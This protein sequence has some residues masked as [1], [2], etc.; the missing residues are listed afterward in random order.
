LSSNHRRPLYLYLPAALLL[1]GALVYGRT[2]GA[3]DLET[4]AREIFPEAVSVSPQRDVL[5]IYDGEE[6]LIGWAGTG[7]ATGYGG[8]MVLLV[9][10]DTLGQVVGIRVIEQRETPIFWR[11]VRSSTYFDRLLGSHFD[12][13]DYGYADVVGVTGATR[14][15]DA[16]VQSVRMAVAE[17]AG[18]VFDVRLPLP[19]RPFEFGLLEIVILAL[20]AVGIGARRLKG[21]IR[22]RVRWGSQITALIVLGFWKDSPITLAKITALLSGYLPDIRT[23][24]AIYLLLAGFLLTSFFYGRNLYCLYACP[25]GA[26][27]RVVGLIGG[28]RLKLPQWSI[29]L[30][31]GTRNVVVFAALFAAFLTLRPVLASYEPFAALFSLHGTTL[32]WFLLFVV[33]VASLAVYTPWCNFFC[34]MRTF[35]VAIQDVKRW[36][37]GGSPEDVTGGA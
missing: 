3:P 16:I 29:R 1:V 15:S 25:F 13:I 32:Q 6:V 37:R 18:E 22:G 30:M 26:A 23:S 33:L 20:F 12:D 5:H 28:F 34:P 8:P 27:Q 24:L 19:R 11:M 36:R 2:R 9:G 21:A 35:E 4:P 17:V 7:S 14:S 10:I 31:E